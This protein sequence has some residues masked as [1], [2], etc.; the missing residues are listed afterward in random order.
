MVGYNCCF[1]ITVSKLYLLVGYNCWLV[2]T[3]G[4]LYLL[5]GHSFWLDR[6]VGWSELSVSWLLLLVVVVVVVVGH[7]CWL[8]GC[9]FGLVITAGWLGCSS[10][11]DN[12]NKQQ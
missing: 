1:V 6:T 7:K 5:V 10:S 12:N 8:V 3:G 2:I 9:C 4:W 11:T